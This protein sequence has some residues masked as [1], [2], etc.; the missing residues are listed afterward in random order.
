MIL[1]I[2]LS[3]VVAK[4]AGSGNFLETG[5]YILPITATTDK[6]AESGRA[7]TE[8][9][10][11]SPEGG[12]AWFNV[13]H[14]REGDKARMFEGY[15]NTLEA[16]EYTAEELDSGSLQ[17]NTEDWVG[18]NFAFFYVAGDKAIGKYSVV[19]PLNPAAYLEEQTSGSLAAAAAHAAAN[20]SAAPR[21]AAPA[22]AAASAPIPA[23]RAA[24]PAPAAAP[25]AVRPT[26]PPPRQ[27][28]GFAPPTAGAVGPAAGGLGLR[29]PTR[30]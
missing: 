8:L 11:T 21:A 23:P 3:G 1:D 14:L 30:Q 13:N 16:M 15:R 18:R 9:V 28:G 5:L 2:N 26:V 27:G 12:K 25:T 7:M 6:T 10:M 4:A 17:I 20:P 29:P 22:P 24:A 19:T